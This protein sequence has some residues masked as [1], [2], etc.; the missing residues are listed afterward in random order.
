MLHAMFVYNNMLSCAIITLVHLR[1]RTFNR[2][3]GPF[4]GSPLTLLTGAVPYAS[5][6]RVFRCTFFVKVPD[7]LGR[8]LG[9]KAFRSVMVGYSQNSPAYHV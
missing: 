3:V 6:F 7:N 1:I 8:K 5:T 9:L 2:A 4:G